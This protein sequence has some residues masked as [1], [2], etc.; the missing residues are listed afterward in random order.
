M[1]NQTITYNNSRI[2]LSHERKKKAVIDIYPK[3]HL[4]TYIREGVL[5]VK[6]GKEVQ[7]FTKG[8]FVLLKKYTQATITKTWENDGV[9]FSSFVFSFQED[10][11]QEAFAQLHFELPQKN[12]V[13]IENVV[14][15]NANPIL[16]Q[17]IS[18]LQLFFEE[19]IPM[20]NQLA[21]LKTSEALIGMIKSDDTLAYQLQNYAVKGK[22]DLHHYMKFHYL[23]NKKLIEFA[24]ESGRS[25]ST[26]KKDFQALYHITPAKWIKKKRLEHAHKLL[27]TTHRKPSDIY[28][29]CGFEDLAHFS[30]SFKAQYKVN[31]SQIVTL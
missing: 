10:L 7:M 23:E 18:S 25:I 19:G 5:K 21:R 12:K 11:V 8:E 22:A 1:I 31:P 30:K 4:L 15:I 2:I 16:K 20:D 26:F 28:L 9:K 24:R 3:H 29:E 27:T 17:F 6:Q 13:P 14:G